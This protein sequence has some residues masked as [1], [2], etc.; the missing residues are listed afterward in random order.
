MEIFQ[1]F[2]LLGSCRMPFLINACM[3]RSACTPSPCPQGM[4][5]HAWL[6]NNMQY[7][8]S[9]SY[10]CWLWHCGQGPRTGY[11]SY[12]K[13]DILASRCPPPPVPMPM[14]KFNQGCRFNL[15]SWQ[16]LLYCSS[17]RPSPYFVVKVFNLL[18]SV[19]GIHAAKHCD[20]PQPGLEEAIYM[21]SGPL[22]KQNVKQ[23]HA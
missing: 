14:F 11:L 6:R 15:H 1:R 20:T 4:A 2:R 9:R 3:L 23:Q 5:W 22:L 18:H 21:R 13:H 16:L 12:F 19:C 8:G 7:H 10:C 17:D